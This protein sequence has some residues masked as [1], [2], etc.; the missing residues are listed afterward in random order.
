VIAIYFLLISH[1]Y[2][3]AMRGSSPRR[4]LAAVGTANILAVQVFV[5]IGG[6]LGVLPLTGV[7]L[8]FASYGG[9]SMVA[10]LALAGIL[11]GSTAEVGSASA[12][13]VAVAPRGDG[14]DG[15]D[16]DVS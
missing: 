14:S 12:E 1:A 7:T 10:S 6:N 3:C 13:A 5:I 16:G 9:S 8:P 2:A 4:Q 15:C 11:L